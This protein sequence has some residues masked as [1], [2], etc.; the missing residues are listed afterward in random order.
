MNLEF[1]GVFVTER[2]FSFEYQNDIIAFFELKPEKWFNPKNLEGKALLKP[3]LSNDIIADI[4]TSYIVADIIV[5][6][7]RRK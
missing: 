6:I 5:N 7:L 3:G 2:S 1:Q 4:F